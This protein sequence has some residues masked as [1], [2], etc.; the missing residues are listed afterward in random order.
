[1]DSYSV[2]DD[3]DR[4]GSCLLID[5]RRRR[6]VDRWSE[7]A[8]ADVMLYVAEDNDD[9]LKAFLSAS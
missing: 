9:L 8:D 3:A 7:R 4:S 1:M 2:P 6:V 5:Q